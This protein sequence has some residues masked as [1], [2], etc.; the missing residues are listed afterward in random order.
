MPN[1]FGKTTDKTYLSVDNAEE[2]GFLHRD[3]IAHCF[4]WTHIVKYL[5]EKKRYITAEILDL[6]CGR[7][8]PLL[9]T[10]YTARML[11]RSYVGLDVGPINPLL[12]SLES[13]SEGDHLISL[14]PTV[15]ILDI[16]NYTLP[17]DPNLIVMFEVL[18]HVEK[19]DGIKIL[20][21]IRDLLKE[22][23]GCIFFMST[24]CY[25]GNNKAGNHVYEWTY[26]E[27]AEQLDDMGFSLI[28][29]WGTFASIKDY[30]PLM[31]AAKLEVFNALRSYY[32][33]NV[34]STIFAPL[35]P[36]ASRNCLWM[37]TI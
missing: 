16:P 15:T 34:L 9:K 23:K 7:E 21:I 25:D 28:D 24:P 32:D 14:Y 17:I 19:E 4:R 12:S 3:Y 18:E 26:N 2:R 10:L 31:S 33:S 29:V 11:P 6:G 20:E 36:N 22:N 1:A 8:Y 35:Y 37:L 30:K 13:K 5:N 27:L